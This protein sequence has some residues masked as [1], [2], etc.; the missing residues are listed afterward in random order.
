MKNLLLFTTLMAAGF[1]TWA[2]NSERVI[3]SDAKTFATEVSLQ[4]VRCSQ[5]GYGSEELKI[6]LAGLDGWTLFDHSNNASGD[7]NGQPCMTAGICKA[8]WHNNGH[9]IDDVVQNRP[10]TETV[11]VVRKVI[12]VK[13]ETKNADNIDVC[14]R[15]LREELATTVRGIAFHHV[16]TGF[17]QD[18]PIEVC[19]P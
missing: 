19:R 9:T 14:Q 13:T 6:N 15:S 12:E 17:D 5:I 16:R 1:S 7:L 8:P 4:T 10:G 2:A 18:F 3:L 11:T